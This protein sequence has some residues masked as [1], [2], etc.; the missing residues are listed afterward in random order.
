MTLDI[1][2]PHHVGLVAADL[3]EATK[4]YER[5]GFQMTP[6]SHHMVTIREGEPPRPLGTANTT[7]VFPRNYVEVVAQVRD[8]VPMRVLDP[9]L[10]RF[11]GFH[12]LA[13][14]TPDADAVV[15]RLDSVEIAHGGV[16]TLER[17]TDTADGPQQL[18][19]RNVMF[20]GEDPAKRVVAWSDARQPEG[21]IQAVENQ[22]PEVLLQKRYQDHPN[23]A[24]D[25]SVVVLCV[26]DDELADV[27]RRYAKYLGQEAHDEGPARVFVLDQSRIM[28]VPASRLEQLLPGEQPPALPAFVA[29]GIAVRDIAAT[30]RLLEGNGFPVTELR[31]GSVM[32]PA[33]AALGGAVIFS[34]AG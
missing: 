30:R 33:A 34:E 20:G 13:L 10:Q 8:D 21:G 32:V 19:F 25:L 14:N 3:D 4:L 5:L 22:T 29:I 6:P 15:T 18:R 17:P 24:I 2:H 28:L 11:P 26:A 23:G 9:W 7:A 1:D 12:I 27:E 16:S 31:T